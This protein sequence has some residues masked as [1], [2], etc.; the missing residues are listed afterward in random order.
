VYD[1]TGERAARLS[2]LIDEVVPRAGEDGE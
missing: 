2:R 1:T